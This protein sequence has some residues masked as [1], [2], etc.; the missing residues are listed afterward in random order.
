MALKFAS[1]LEGHLPHIYDLTLSWRFDGPLKGFR[2]DLGRGLDHVDG[3]H[4]L[5]NV[6]DHVIRAMRLVAKKASADVQGV[7]LVESAVATRFRPLCVNPH[8][9]GFIDTNVHN[10]TKLGRN[11]EM[12]VSSV[13]EGETLLSMGAKPSIRI[14]PIHTLRS[15]VRYLNYAYVAFGLGKVGSRLS[16][17]YQRAWRKCPSTEERRRLNQEVILWVQSFELAAD[18]RFRAVRL[19][20]FAHR[21]KQTLKV[22]VDQAAID[23]LARLYDEIEEEDRLNRHARIHEETADSSWIAGEGTS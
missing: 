16:E 1:G 21:H 19:G 22:P 13:P 10:I 20:T 14:R 4:L 18:D 17:V 7:M 3:A 9:H 6:W 2:L 11:L 12:I 8:F 5:T 15:F 23:H